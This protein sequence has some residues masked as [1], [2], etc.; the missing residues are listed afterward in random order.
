MLAEGSYGKCHLLTRPCVYGD[1]SSSPPDAADCASNLCCVVDQVPKSLPCGPSHQKGETEYSPKQKVASWLQEQCEKKRCAG[2]YAADL[3]KENR[4]RPGYLQLEARGGSC[5][6]MN[7]PMARARC[8]SSPP[9]SISR[10][11]VTMGQY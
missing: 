9:V 7:S 6:A 8:C 2:F 10:H 3:G 1:P 4:A 5:S 11:L